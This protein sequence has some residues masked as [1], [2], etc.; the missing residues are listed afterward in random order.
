MKGHRT[1][2]ST[3]AIS[4]KISSLILAVLILGATRAMPAVESHVSASASQQIDALLAADWAKHNLKPNPPASDEVFVRR[5]YLDVIGRIPT[6][7]EAAE[8]LGSNDAQKR[9]KLIDNLLASE[10]Y[11]QNFF[12]YWADILRA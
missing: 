11:A 12:P 1:E 6:Y 3:A 10:G 4:V 2:R 7:R 8:F 5:V 9:T